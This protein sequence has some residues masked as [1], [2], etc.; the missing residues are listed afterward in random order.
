MAK[1]E[2]KRSVLIDGGVYDHE[3]R[4]ITV[5]MKDGYVEIPIDDVLSE[6]DGYNIKIVASTDILED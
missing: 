2:R 1:I 6:I 4:T 3:T 5:E